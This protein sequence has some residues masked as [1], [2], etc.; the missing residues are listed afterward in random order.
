MKRCRECF[1]ELSPDAVHC[2]QC[3]RELGPPV[4]LPEAGS[5]WSGPAA[6]WRIATI[7]LAAIGGIMLLFL[8][9]TLLNPW[10]D[11]DFA[12]ADGSSVAGLAPP[13]V[14][15]LAMV[16]ATAEEIGKAYDENE[17]TARDR[18]EGRPIRLTGTVTRIGSNEGEPTLLL[19]SSRAIQAAFADP[20]PL[21]TLKTG[22]EVK[23]TCEAMAGMGPGPG[24]GLRGCV[25]TA[26]GDRAAPVERR[27]GPQ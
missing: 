27:D 10:G 4:T 21:K 6:N 17:L 15:N 18:F 25:V 26:Q 14:T 8:I 2:P 16:E 1:A 20:E 12:P 5:A 24:L 9:G 23:I 13:P 22:Q 7:V 11:A 19:Q 3:G